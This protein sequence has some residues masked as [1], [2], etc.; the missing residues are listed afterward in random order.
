MHNELFILTLTANGHIAVFSLEGEEEISG[1]LFT[2][3]PEEQ[4]LPLT[5]VTIDKV[6]DDDEERVQLVVTT[7]RSTV[8]QVELD[9]QNDVIE[10]VP[11]PS[12]P[13]PI[14]ALTVVHSPRAFHLTAE[15][16]YHSDCSGTHTLL[17]TLSDSS[18][19]A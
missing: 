4:R 19:Y 8:M 13:Y 6:I 11:L 3:L 17:A 14:T 1:W 10:V 15:E 16:T 18:L 5:S 7:M 9:I 2:S 12:P